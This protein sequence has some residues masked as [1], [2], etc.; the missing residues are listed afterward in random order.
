MSDE[1][2]RDRI[3]IDLGGL[4]ER[5]LYWK[6]E[7]K[8]KTG[9]LIRIV[10]LVGLELWEE[11]D[12]RGIEPPRPG[13]IG[14]WLDSLLDTKMSAVKPPDR[15]LSQIVSTWDLSTLAKLTGIRFS[16]V[17]AIASGAKPAPE[18]LTRL[19]SQLDESLEELE[20]IVERD[21]DGDK[22]EKTNGAV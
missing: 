19:E 8:Q 15:S 22:G 10:L 3:T 1:R 2:D 6:T 20:A 11:L 4:R 9:S 16:R 21:F 17:K 7:P 14:N 12:R 5:I 13:R 18:E